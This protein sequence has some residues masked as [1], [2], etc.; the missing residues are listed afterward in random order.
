MKKNKFTLLTMIAIL[1]FLL[2]PVP[3]KI[4]SGISFPFSDK[5]VHVGLFALLAAIF[6]LEKFLQKTKIKSIIKMFACFLAFAVLTEVLQYFTGY[7]SFDF[8]DIFADIL[9]IIIGTIISTRIF[10]VKNQ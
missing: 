1:I 3:Q 10:K 2:M 4:S 7:R 8:Y 9:G 6:V 5:I